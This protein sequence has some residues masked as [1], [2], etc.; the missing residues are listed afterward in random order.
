MNRNLDFL[1]AWRRF[2]ND[3]YFY[4]KASLSHVKNEFGL[5]GKPEPCRALL[6]DQIVPSLL[7]KQNCH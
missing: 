5:L 7:P 3:I 4:S 6:F 1:N 2:V